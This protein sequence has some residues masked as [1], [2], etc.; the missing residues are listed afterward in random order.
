[1]YGEPPKA[2]A[3]AVSW[4]LN[5]PRVWSGP[6]TIQSIGHQRRNSSSRRGYPSWAQEE[7]PESNH[8]STMSLIRFITEPQFAQSN[9]TSSMWGRWRS[10]PAV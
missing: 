9:S 1:M 2:T 10:I 7:T 3:P 8:T 5:Q 6:S 4:L